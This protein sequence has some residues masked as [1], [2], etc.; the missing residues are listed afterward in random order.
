MTTEKV[1]SRSWRLRKAY[2]TAAVVILSYTRL[3]LG[4][5]IL[6]KAWYERRMADLHLRNAER[7]KTAILQLKGLFI[8]LGQ[9]LSVLGN[10]L[11]VAFQK[12]LEA[13]Q[14]QIPSRPY[15]E[16]CDRIFRELGR[17]PDEI[18]IRFDEEPLAAAS[19]GQ[20]HRAQL[21]DGT[22][23]V[24]K[25]QHLNIERIAAVDLEI[26]RRLT[27][28]FSWFYQIKGMDYLYSQIKKMIEEELDFTREAVSMQKIAQNLE[29]EPF[30]AIPQIHPG[31]STARVM[32]TTW[33]DGVKISNL[34]QLDAW[35][36]NRRD[37][38]VRIL[39]LYC[40]MVFKDGF[41]HADP[42]PG[43]LLVQPDGTLVLLDFGAVAEISP[44]LREG[45]PQLIEAAVKNDTPAMIQACRS[46]GF[47][48]E[49]R[50]AEKMAATMIAAFRNFLQYEVQFEGL[51]LTE[52]KVNPLN[53]SL[54]N[55]INDI[56][57]QGISGVVQ[58]PKDYVLFN[59]T[60]TL[61]LGLC[62]AL[63]ASLNP[64]DVIRPYAKAFVMG[65]KGQTISFVKKLLQRSAS[66]IMGLPDEISRVLQQV[67][68]GEFEF[69]SSDIR[70]AAKLLYSAFH[71]LA[72][73]LLG[74]SAGGLGW[75]LHSAGDTSL[76]RVAFGFAGF[77][78][79][80]MFR[81]MRWGKRVLKGM[82]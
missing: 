4:K 75:L 73:M 2:G 7:V 58:V 3:W 1:F 55:L 38:A 62:A 27:A 30:F 6:G 21:P 25:V 47:L 41:Y 53:N 20:A 78:L 9:L 15:S 33:Y 24:V 48:A 63:D 19:I 40:R 45:I 60:A 67:Q 35:G 18:F 74:L 79:L 46:M 52:I 32:T 68:K 59:R 76:S 69:Q 43:N 37:L 44:A 57:L 22:E 70:S 56:G 49:G 54:T 42:H 13:L 81:A 5:K 17:P 36:I 72:F 77:F 16:V 26:I 80:L 82:S 12:P 39:Q 29:G 61:L 14:D 64:L 8:K 28:I 34:A 71:Q 51:N 23:V 66:T 31:Y 10:F 11:P 65:E 50:E